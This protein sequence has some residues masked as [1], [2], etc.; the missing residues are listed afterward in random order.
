MNNFSVLWD[1]TKF[2]SK[3]EARKYCLSKKCEDSISYL[4]GLS[5]SLMEKAATEVPVQG[6]HGYPMEAP[7]STEASYVSAEANRLRDLR[8]YFKGIKPRPG[9]KW[10]Y[11]THGL[12][13][14]Y[15]E[16]DTSNISKNHPAFIDYC[17][18]AERKLS[19]SEIDKA[20]KLWESQFNEEL[21]G[22][23]AMNKIFKLAY[24][25]KMDDLI[26]ESTKL[27]GMIKKKGWQSW[28][29]CGTLADGQTT[30]CSKGIYD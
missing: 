18:S 23:S 12:H 16:I 22:I 5:Y 4:D 3:E 6:G 19:Q 27:K 20:Y 8:K 2:N 25:F 29:Y 15:Q 13:S 17:K 30:N 1:Y 9:Y 26:P 11:S 24:H 10:V 7:S 14:V 21:T 28:Y